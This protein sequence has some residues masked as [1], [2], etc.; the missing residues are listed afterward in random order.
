MS[1][2]AKLFIPSKAVTAT[3]HSNNSGDVVK[4]LLSLRH[5]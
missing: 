5:P 4:L 3:K 1:E 2:F